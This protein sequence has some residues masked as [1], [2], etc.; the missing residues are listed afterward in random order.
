M[1]LTNRCGQPLA[2]QTWNPKAFELSFLFDEANNLERN[3]G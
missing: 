2:R 1:H 3:L